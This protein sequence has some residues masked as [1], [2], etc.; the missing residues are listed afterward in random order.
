MVWPPP[1]ILVED[2]GPMM[3]SMESSMKLFDTLCCWTTYLLIGLK[4]IG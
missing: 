3:E 1:S 4:C 2:I